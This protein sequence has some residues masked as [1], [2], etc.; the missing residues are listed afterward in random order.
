MAHKFKK[1]TEHQRQQ[2]CHQNDHDNFPRGTVTGVT[3]N[4]VENIQRSYK[5]L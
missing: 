4:A 2:K 5:I 1:K 3:K